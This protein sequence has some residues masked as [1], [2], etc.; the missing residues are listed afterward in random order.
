MFGFKGKTC[1]DREY[2]AVYQCPVGS[3]CLNLDDG[4]ECVA[5]LTL[6]GINSSI[7]YSPSFTN[8]QRSLNEITITYRSQV[9]FA[10]IFV[11]SN[12]ISVW[13]YSFAF[14]MQ[15][16]ICISEVLN[17]VCYFFIGWRGYVVCSKYRCQYLDRFQ[18]CFHCGGANQWLCFSEDFLLVKFYLGWGLACAQSYI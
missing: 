16:L 13:K 4:Y 2:C 1:E 3:E 14:C 5:N 10:Q 8:L 18:S 11:E 6:N 15:G 9:R 12:F 17:N 7:T